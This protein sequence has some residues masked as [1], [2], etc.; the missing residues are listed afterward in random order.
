MVFMFLVTFVLALI[1]VLKIISYKK[2]EY[3]HQ[4]GFSFFNACFDLGKYG[5]YL[6]YRKLTSL[7]GYKKFLFN[8]YLPKDDGTTTELDVILIHDSGV[9][10]FESKNYSGWIFGSE[11]SKNWTQS[12]PVGKGKSRKIKFFNPIMQNKVHI[13]WLK[14]YINDECIPFYSCI[15]FSD[16]CTL[17]RIKLT[18]NEHWVIQRK[19]I[20]WRVA[21]N[22]KKVGKI[23]SNDEIDSIF[24]SLYLLTQLTDEEKEMHIQQIKDKHTRK[25]KKK[26]KNIE[27]SVPIDEGIDEKINEEIND[28]DDTKEYIE[29]NICETQL[30]DIKSEE[31]GMVNVDEKEC[32]RCGEK[33]VIRKAKRGSNAGKD[34]WGCTNYPKCR[35]IETK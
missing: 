18:S 5:E 3:Y 11:T 29:D 8:C 22:A 28:I 24:Q 34:F 7:S 32:P 9:Y 1:L 19:N 25:N 10:I 14:N 33:M 21:K 13:K 4:T 31:R 12:L 27:T 16:R 26:V 35:Y 30:E 6:T 15:V 20:L 23:I 17:K 2:T